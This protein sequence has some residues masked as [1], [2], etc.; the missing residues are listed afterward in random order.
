MI[1]KIYF[2]VIAGLVLRKGLHF[3]VDGAGFY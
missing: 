3:G 1:S 2:P